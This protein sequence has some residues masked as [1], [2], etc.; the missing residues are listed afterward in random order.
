MNSLLA[1]SEQTAGGKFSVVHHIIFLSEVSKTDRNIYSES[2]C[3]RDFLKIL[4]N[5]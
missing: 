5:P 1:K 2:F 4:E 3:K